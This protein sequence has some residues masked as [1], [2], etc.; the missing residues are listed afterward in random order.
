M[1]GKLQGY[2][3]IL[4][5]RQYEDYDQNNQPNEKQCQAETKF[6][7]WKGLRLAVV[8]ESEGSRSVGVSSRSRNMSSRSGKHEWLS[9]NVEHKWKS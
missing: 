3:L 6:A 4:L 8:I 5:N 7:P 2:A 1:Y 9:Q